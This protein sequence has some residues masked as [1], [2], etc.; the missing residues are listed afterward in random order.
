MTATTNRPVTKAVNWAAMEPLYR[1]GAVPLAQLA[2]DFCVSRAAIHKHA[3]KIGWVRAVRN[4]PGQTTTADHQDPAVADSSS[5]VGAAPLGHPEDLAREVVALA[6]LAQWVTS[7][8][9][10]LRRVR[11]VA[12]IS[13]AVAAVFDAH[14][15]R[16]NTPCWFEL[17]VD[18]GLH[19]MTSRQVELVRRL[20]G[21]APC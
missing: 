2:R 3:A 15:L 1:A 4:E 21:T 12:Q 7:A 20:G 6:N 14:D 18:V 19:Y 9:T 8:E 13:P 11:T 5:T 16:I 10:L 17:E